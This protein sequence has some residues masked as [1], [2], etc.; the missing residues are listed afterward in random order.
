MTMLFLQDRID[1]SVEILRMYEPPEGYFLAFSGGKDSI[2]LYAMAERAGVRFDAHYHITTADPPE[3][4]RFIRAEY[5]GVVHDHS[6]WTMW[7]LIPHKLMPPTRLVR[8]CCDILKEGG[9]EGRV[10]LT[11]VKRSDST[12]RRKSQVYSCRKKGKSVVNPLLNW[13]D[14]EIWTYI[15]STGMRY[16]ELYDQ[17]F[18]RLGCIGC[19]MAGPARQKMG[20]ERWPKFREAY[21]RAFSRMLTVRHE[22]GLKTTQ[23][24]TAEEVMSWWLRDDPATEKEGA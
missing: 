7:T 6:A 24:N 5:P 18:S 4:I 10:V 12:A 2:V 17:G 22:R 1:E 11:G 19:P 14:D 23:W 20:F 9:G 15:R 3:L 21:L 8:Y 16:C 13:C